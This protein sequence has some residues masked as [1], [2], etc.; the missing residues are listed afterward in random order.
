MYNKQDNRLIGVHILLTTYDI[1]KI[2]HFT[3]GAD[4]RLQNNNNLLSKLN[5]LFIVV[6]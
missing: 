1:T 2:Q 4:E 6:L 5:K 3:K